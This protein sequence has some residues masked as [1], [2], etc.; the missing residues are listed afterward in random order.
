[1]YT[2]ISRS[3]S[4]ASDDEHPDYDIVFKIDPHQTT[5]KRYVVASPKF[6]S[7]QLTRSL[8]RARSSQLLTSADAEDLNIARARATGKVKGQVYVS[9]CTVEESSVQLSSVVVE[10]VLQKYGV[11]YVAVPV[12]ERQ[13]SYDDC[14]NGLHTSEFF[15][16]LLSE[17]AEWGRGG[18]GK[19][20]AMDGRAW[21]GCFGS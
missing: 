21:N 5:G 13:Y 16:A 15:V 20:L 18:G 11:K 4:E 19:V 2:V 8:S 17:G 7:P 9:F 12:D 3:N 10:S 1:M 14:M 6:T